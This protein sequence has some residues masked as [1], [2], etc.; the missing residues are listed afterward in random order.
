MGWLPPY[1]S[2]GESDEANESLLERNWDTPQSKGK[3][4]PF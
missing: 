1:N 2:P 3:S 4:M